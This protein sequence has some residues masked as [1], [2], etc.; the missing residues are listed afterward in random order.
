MSA[1]INIKKIVNELLGTGITQQELA[2]K[3]GYD[4]CGI[5]KLKRGIVKHPPFYVVDSLR[6]LHK[7]K[8]KNRKK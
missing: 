1:E 8:F 4:Q 7:S 3:C 5:S 6:E 2:D